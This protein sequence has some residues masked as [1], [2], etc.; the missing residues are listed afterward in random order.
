M[1]RFAGDP[2]LVTQYQGKVRIPNLAAT[3]EKKSG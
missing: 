3:S 2:S 1:S